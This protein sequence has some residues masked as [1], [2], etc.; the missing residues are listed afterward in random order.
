[1]IFSFHSCVVFLGLLNIFMTFLKFLSGSSY[2]LVPL[3]SIFGDLFCSFSWAQWYCFLHVPYYFVRTCA[4]ED[5]AISPAFRDC[6]CAGEDLHRWV[7]IEIL[8]SSQTFSLHASIFSSFVGANS[9]LK[10]FCRFLFS[11][12]CNLLLPLVSVCCT[13]GPLEQQ[14]A[15]LLFS[16]LSKPQAFRLSQVSSVL[17]NRWYRNQSLWWLPENLGHWTHTSTLS[18]LREKP[19]FGVFLYSFFIELWRRA[20]VNE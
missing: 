12:A 10:K 11:G 3:G 16:I 5:T 13:V 4:L 15:V 20:M 6:L 19:D 17:W 2:I 18:F 8:R 1:M 7:Q 9:Q 14:Q